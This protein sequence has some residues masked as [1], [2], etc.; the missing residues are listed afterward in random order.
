MNISYKHRFIFIHN[1]KV[2][3]T[4]ITQAL[5]KYSLV[6]PV[7]FTHINILLEHLNKDRRGQLLLRKTDR[8]KKRIPSIYKFNIH[9][10]AYKIK[11]KL[12]N[13]IW[14]NFFKF[15]FVRNP[16]EWQVSL[17]HYML[18]EKDHFQH[19]LIKNMKTFQEYIEWRVFKHKHLQKEFFY[20][21]NGNCLVDYIGKLEN[22][23]EDFEK[24]C[25]KIGI[26]EKLP[27]INK[28][29]HK[30]YKKYYNYYTIDLIAK[31]FKEDIEL[32]DYKF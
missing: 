15:G 31:H 16:W 22:I 26:E 32:F 5:R 2:G 21:E 7:I 23:S 18:Q 3:G 9:D 12:P 4:S 10:T 27:H 17:Y 24:I 29:G 28:S 25:N 1:Y 11:E 6:N 19:N 13:N 8:L 20:D 30:Y 14:N